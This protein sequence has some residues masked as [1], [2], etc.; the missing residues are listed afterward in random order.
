MLCVEQGMNDYGL[1]LKSGRRIY[2]PDTIA[3]HKEARAFL[4]TTLAEPHDGPTVVVTHHLPSYQSVHPTFYNLPMSA[5]NGGFYSDLNEIINRFDID[6]WFHGHTH[7]AMNYQLFGT[8][9]CANPVGYAGIRG[10]ADTG[11]NPSWRIEV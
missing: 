7:Q 3:L 6:Y 2:A 1:I 8:K 4:E 9:I 10:C 11:F 5:L